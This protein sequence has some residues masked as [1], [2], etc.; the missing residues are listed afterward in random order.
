M[1]CEDFRVLIEDYVDG[2]LDHKSAARVTSHTAT[3]AECASF[4][5]ELSREQ[6]LYARYQRDV[7][8]TPV[9]WASIEARIKQERA[10][11]P[12]GFISRLREQLAAAFA[13]PRLSPA[14][15]AVLVMVA[16]GATVF[17]MSRLNSNEPREVALAN[18]NTSVITPPVSSANSNLAAPSTTPET[19]KDKMIAGGPANPVREEEKGPAPVAKQPRRVQTAMTPAQLVRDAEDKYLTAIAMLSRDVNRRRSQLDPMM[20][21]RFDA[22]LADID[23]TIKETRQVVRGNP[24]DPIALQ[25]LLAAYSKKVDVLREMTNN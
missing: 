17:V 9:I 20:L 12:Q 22:S 3:C 19:G 7:E 21:A 10:A 15:A 6:E 2:S 1:K 23:R 16:I 18:N 25:Y 14:F 5:Q 4:Y 24:G 8:V 13:A 11:Q